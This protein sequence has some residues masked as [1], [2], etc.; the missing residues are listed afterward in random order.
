[1]YIANHV[2]DLCQVRFFVHLRYC[3]I[4]KIGMFA[5]AMFIALW[6]VFIGKIFIVHNVYGVYTQGLPLGSMLAQYATVLYQDL[7]LL[8]VMFF[9]LLVSRMLNKQILRRI[10]NIVLV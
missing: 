10:V 5:K 4:L 3:F 2:L 6:I 1:M 7:F 8:G 9:L